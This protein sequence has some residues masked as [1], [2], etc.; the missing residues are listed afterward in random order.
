[1]LWEA[2]KFTGLD[3]SEAGGFVDKEADKEVKSVKQ[4]VEDA[5]WAE[6]EEEGLRI[7]GVLC[8]RRERVPAMP[9][10]QY[11]G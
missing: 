8:F 7:R 6:A 11:L 9:T 3:N 5:L 10:A 2:P 1:M 4:Q